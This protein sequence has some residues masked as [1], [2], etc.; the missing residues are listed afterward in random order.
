[1]IVLTNFWGFISTHFPSLAAIGAIAGGIF[2]FIK[3]YDIRNR[4]LAQKNWADYQ[5]ALDVVWGRN[6]SGQDISSARQLAA[7]YRLTRFKEFYFATVVALEE[8]GERNPEDWKRNVGPGAK[9]VVAALKRT[10][11]YKSQARKFEG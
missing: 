1:M 9:R 2:T 10:C 3:W 7:L 11:A 6:M 4:E 8:A 5:E